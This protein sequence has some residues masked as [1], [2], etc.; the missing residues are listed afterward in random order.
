MPPCPFLPHTT[1]GDERLYPDKS[2]SYSKALLHDGYGRVNSNA[3]DSLITALNSG[4]PS[5]FENII[6][7]GTV[8]ET[9]P[10]SGLAFDLEGSDVV[11]FGN[12][13]SPANQENLVVVPPPPAVASAAYGTEL[14]ELYWTSLLRDVAFTDYPTNSI[15]ALAAA[16]LSSMPNY[17]GPRN[18]QGHVTPNLLFRGG[19]RR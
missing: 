7:G 6:L 10:Q 17:A 2:A 18:S 1:N 3:Y 15:A 9:D 5:D 11:Q 16:E 8:R 4:N 13:P 19:F 12:A 14:V